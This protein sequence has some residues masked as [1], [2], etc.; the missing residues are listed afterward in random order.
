MKREVLRLECLKMA[1]RPDRSPAQ[2]FALAKEYESFV[3]EAQ[4]EDEEGKK[5][6]PSKK[7]AGK[8]DPLS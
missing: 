4:D 1:H 5:S 7:G 6:N 8:P 2:V 3:L